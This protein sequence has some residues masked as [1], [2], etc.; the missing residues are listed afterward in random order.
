[1]PHASD[2]PPSGAMRALGRGRPHRAGDLLPRFSRWHAARANRWEWLHLQRG[3]LVLQWLGEAG[4]LAR[5]LGDGQSLWLAPGHRW[6]IARLSED[7]EF[8]LQV[9]ADDSVIADAPQPERARLLE[10]APRLEAADAAALA[11]A[12][13]D[14]APGERRLLRTPFDPA[15]C[16]REAL[17]DSGGT[18]TWHPLGADAGTHAALLVRCAEPVDLL[19]YLGRDHALIEA[20]LVG[21]LGGDAGRERWLRSLLARHLRIE[22]QDIFP[23]FLAAGGDPAT[24]RALQRE[25]ELLRGH[26]DNIA[27]PASHRGLLLVLEAHDEKEEQLVYPDF[28]A[29]IGS[30]AAALTAAIIARGPG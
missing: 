24:V 20:A 26:L 2:T 22:E 18:L 4:S 29:R 9:F 3:E 12:L 15:P 16:V 30:R 23:A 11:Q 6:R 13:A 8:S 5:S 28:L 27:D 19:D 10:A 7:A 21:A 14:L 17:A 25:H 1:M